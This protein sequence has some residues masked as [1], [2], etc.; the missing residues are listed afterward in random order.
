[1]V[2]L[3]VYKTHLQPMEELFGVGQQPRCYSKTSSRHLAGI[4]R[5]AGVGE[6][7]VSVRLW[8]EGRGGEIRTEDQDLVGGWGWGSL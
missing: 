6:G 3:L 7:S 2:P 1:M 8:G 4:G 5:A